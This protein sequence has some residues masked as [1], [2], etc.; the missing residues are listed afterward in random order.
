VDRRAANRLAL[1]FGQD[2][3][4]GQQ[5]KHKQ[6]GGQGGRTEQLLSFRRHIDSSLDNPEGIRA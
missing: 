2:Q 5:E 6:Q 3:T 1:D 4:G